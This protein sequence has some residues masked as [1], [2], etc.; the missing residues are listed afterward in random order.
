MAP[1][2]EISYSILEVVAPKAAITQPITLNE[3]KFHVKNTRALL[4]RNELNKNRT[5]D[6]EIIQDLG[7]VELISVDRSE[8]CDLDIGCNFLR[9][10][11]KIPGFVEL[12]HKVMATRIGPVDKLSRPYQLIAYERVPFEFYNKFTRNE[13]KCFLMNNNDYLYLA[14]YKDN[15]LNKTLKKINIQG[16][17]EDPTEVKPFISC[18]GAICYSDDSNYPVK[19]WMINSIKDIVIRMYIKPETLAPIDTSNDSKINPQ[20]TILPN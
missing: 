12:H 7:C 5:A 15:I 14:I 8:C 1:L 18:S 2:N 19:E 13:I 9:T 20:P 4:I 16:V 10:K 11:L 6:P 17:F 3:I